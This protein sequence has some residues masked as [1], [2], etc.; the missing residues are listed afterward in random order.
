M[1][2]IDKTLE[3]E[4]LRDDLATMSASFLEVVEE[5]RTLAARNERLVEALKPFILDGFDLRN[6]ELRVDPGT[7]RNIKAARRELENN[8]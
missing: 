3:I 1:S 4:K 2:R 7:F 5:N 6:V 8:K